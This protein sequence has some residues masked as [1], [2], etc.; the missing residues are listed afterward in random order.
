MNYELNDRTSS[1]VSAL[2]ADTQNP[3]L[4]TR[5]DEQTANPYVA[6][7]FQPINYDVP[8][9]RDVRASFAADRNQL[10]VVSSS[11]HIRSLIATVFLVAGFA[12]GLCVYFLNPGALSTG[13]LVAILVCSYVFYLL[14]ACICNDLS[15]YLSH[16]GRGTLFESQY[17]QVR[18]LIGRFK[19]YAECYHNELRVHTNYT[20]DSNGN[21]HLNTYT[22]TE[23]VITH[24]ATEYVTPAS[25][26]DISGQADRI[27]AQKSIVFIEFLVNYR[28]KTDQCRMRLDQLYHRFQ[29]LN[30]RDQ[31]QNYSML[32]EIPG[33]VEKQSFYVGE[34]NCKYLQWFFL[35]GAVGLVWP[36]SLWV[37]S[38][39]DR[40]NINL[41]KVLTF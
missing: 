25:T 32:Y 10:Q 4:A 13:G 29:M 38:K 6:G 39:V 15:S 19:F 3:Y 17:N 16:I 40:F 30:K 14:L 31:F 5:T 26:E 12:S 27:R 28:F 22:T 37:E 18:A 9:D 1:N 20:T 21:Q 35:F 8:V 34:L 7:D 41:T 2:I 11:Y 23:K 36:Y 24:T 33:L